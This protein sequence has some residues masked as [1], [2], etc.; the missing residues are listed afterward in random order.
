MVTHVW[1]SASYSGFLLSNLIHLKR[2]SA[3]CNRDAASNQPNDLTIEKAAQMNTKTCI[4]CKIEKPLTEFGPEKNSRDGRRGQC[5]SCRLSQR[6]E[7]ERIR[8]A[9]RSPRKPMNLRERRHQTFKTKY[10]I[11]IDDYD[12]MLASQNFKCAICLLPPNTSVHQRLAVDHCHETG[13]VRGLLCTHC[14][15][16]LARFGDNVA[17]IT[18]V[19]DY[20]N[21]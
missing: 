7:R 16:S 10:K 2:S 14:N 11:T 17:G 8:P 9:K 1:A 20:L 21:K 12:R 18:R 19:L 4:T 5:R 13:S 6:Q 15:R 3:P